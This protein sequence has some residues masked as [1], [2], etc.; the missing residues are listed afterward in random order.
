MISL[1]FPLRLLIVLSFSHSFSIDL[2]ISRPFFLI[3]SYPTP[4]EASALADLVYRPPMTYWVLDTFL[5]FHD[6]LVSS[7]ATTTLV[8]KSKFFSNSSRDCSNWAASLM[9]N[10]NSSMAYNLW[11]LLL[12]PWASSSPVESV[13]PFFLDLMGSGISSSFF[14]TGAVGVLMETTH[15]RSCLAK[16]QPKEGFC[17]KAD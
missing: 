15:F 11:K 10:P 14:S 16:F 5:I 8:I 4:F 3:S 9:R 17:S 7:T 6:S 13:C 2:I 12:D 1:T